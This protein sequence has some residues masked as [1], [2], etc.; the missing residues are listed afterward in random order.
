M[1]IKK[2]TI[3]LL[4]GSFDPIHYGHLLLA[5][6]M[7]E[8]LNLAE[9]VFIPC[10]QQVLKT[11]AFAS[12]KDRLEMIK[13][14]IADHTSF[15]IDTRELTRNTPSYTYETLC[16]IRDEV[17]TTPLA[18]MMASDALHGLTRW[19]RWQDLL[20]KAH[21]IV[22]LRPGYSLE[23]LDPLLKEWIKEHISNDFNDL[24][25][26]PCGHV[27]LHSISALDISA[28]EIRGQLAMGI[29]PRFLLPENVIKYIHENQLY[30]VK[31]A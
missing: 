22:T 16:S 28:T 11:P 5:Q 8:D 17:G 20:T 13:L 25:N 1:T 26:K 4:G 2:N 12:A 27:F 3:G 23:N 19:H 29:N 30:Q 10:Q 31:D 24:H 14:A 15:R 7:Q 9:I 18:F 21:I 6:Q